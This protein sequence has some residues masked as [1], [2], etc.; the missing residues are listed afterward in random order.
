MPALVVPAV[1]TTPMTSARRGS[2]R[3]AARRAAPVRRWSCVATVSVPIPSTWRA[4]PTDECRV[5]AQS[6]E[7]TQRCCGAAPVL[8]RVAGHH[9]SRQVARRSTGDEAAACSLGE[10]RLR[11][12]H[13]EGLVL[14]HHDASRFE[15]GRA[16]QRRARDEHVEEQ[17]GLGGRG[18]DERQEARAVARDDRRRQLVHEELKHLGCVVSP[19]PHEPRQFGVERLDEATEVECD[20]IHG[21]PFSAGRQNEVGHRLVVVKHLAWHQADGSSGPAVGRWAA[22]QT[23]SARLATSWGGAPVLAAASATSSNSGLAR[24]LMTF[25]RIVMPSTVT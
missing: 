3:S 10:V 1:A 13:P 9:Q 14:G 21:Q 22:R 20:R 12:Q 23:S 5:L 24:P 18:R 17:R 8:G 7:G 2:S 16:V 19:W 4:L 11:R 15:P 6:N 25:I